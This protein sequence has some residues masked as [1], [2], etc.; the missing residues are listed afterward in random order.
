MSFKELID[1][2]TYIYRRV[3][4]GYFFNKYNNPYEK[5]KFQESKS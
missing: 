3:L 4:K 1:V 2:G 5:Q